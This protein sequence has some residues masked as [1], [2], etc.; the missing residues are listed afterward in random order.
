MIQRN[1][2]AA[3]KRVKHAFYR[4]VGMT[5]WRGLWA[6]PEKRPSARPTV[7]VLVSSAKHWYSSSVDR[8]KIQWV[9]SR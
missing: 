3:V 8:Q 5:I 1:I 2:P 4:N 7:P 6:S 9:L